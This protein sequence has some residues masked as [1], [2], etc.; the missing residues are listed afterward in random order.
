MIDGS[1]SGSRRPKNRRIRIRIR[2]TAKNNVLLQKTLLNGCAPIVAVKGPKGCCS[3]RPCQRK[4]R[5]SRHL[6]QA[7]HPGPVGLIHTPLGPSIESVSHRLPT[8]CRGT[9]YRCVIPHDQ[10]GILGLSHQYA[11]R[12]EHGLHQPEAVSFHHAS[13]HMPGQPSLIS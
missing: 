8:R 7:A 3:G 2:N 12:S 4:H 6:L 1:R 13:S 11:C 10:G 9:L 5:H